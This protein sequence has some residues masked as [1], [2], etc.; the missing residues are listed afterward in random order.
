MA[1]APPASKPARTLPPAPQWR[2]QKT[3]GRE[4]QGLRM[5]VERQRGEPF[6]R[7]LEVLVALVGAGKPRFGR[8]RLAP[9]PARGLSTLPRCLMRPGPGSGRSCLSVMLAGKR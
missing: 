5:Q 4:F 7:T 1:L 2:L 6:Y 3:L 9:S 8:H